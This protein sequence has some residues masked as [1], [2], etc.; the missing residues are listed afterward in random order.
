MKRFVSAMPESSAALDDEQADPSKRPAW[1][2]NSGSK[3][4]CS[5]LIFE[6][7]G[8]DTSDRCASETVTALSQQI[9][10]KRRLRKERIRKAHP[11]YTKPDGCL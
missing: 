7:D 6:V 5:V 4:A 10:R 8:I 2:K 1:G 3:A 11:L 9:L